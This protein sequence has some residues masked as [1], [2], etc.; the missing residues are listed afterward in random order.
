[1]PAPHP[2]PG[3]SENTELADRLELLGR[4]TRIV[5]LAPLGEAELRGI[6]VEQVQ[7]YRRELEADG[8][9][10]AVDAAT[11]D[12]LVADALRRGIGA[13]GLRA[14]LTRIVEDLVYETVG[15]DGPDALA[16]PWR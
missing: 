6:V 15:E 2:R 5:E 14:A 16:L 8:L 13:R 11:T 4:F 1:M 12:A 7:R 10:L 9:E 3:R